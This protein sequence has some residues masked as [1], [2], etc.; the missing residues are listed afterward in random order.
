MCGEC[1]RNIGSVP[2]LA[3]FDNGHGQCIHLKGNLCGIYATRPDICNVDTMYEK[4]F[5][6]KYSREEFYDMNM[7]VCK[8]LIEG[9]NSNG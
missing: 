8:L 4:Y 5:K 9:K 6:S 7:K 1:C 2:Q 3:A